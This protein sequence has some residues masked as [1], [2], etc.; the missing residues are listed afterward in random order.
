MLTIQ[1]RE[2]YNIISV[3]IPCF[4]LGAKITPPSHYIFFSILAI[5][6]QWNNFKNMSF[7][8]LDWKLLQIEIM[9]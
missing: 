1:R 7:I 5:I 4:A 6:L 9:N 2:I 3:T 8:M